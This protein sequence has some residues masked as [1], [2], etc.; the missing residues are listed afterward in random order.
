[1]VNYWLAKQEPKSYNFAALKKEVKTVPI[2]IDYMGKTVSFPPII[3]SSMTT[4]TTKTN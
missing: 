1:M 3:N 4:V 2:I